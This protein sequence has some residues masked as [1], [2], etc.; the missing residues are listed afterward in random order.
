MSAPKLIMFLAFMWVI[1]LTISYVA[2]GTW[3]SASDATTMNQ[4]TVIRNYNV[5]GLFD[6]PWINAE[7]F[8]NGLPKLVAWDTGFFGGEARIIQ[9]LFMVVTIGFIFGVLP[10]VISALRVIRG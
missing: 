3:F 1:G 7:F 6:I 10:I 2:D 9:Y 4:L 5:A 8:T